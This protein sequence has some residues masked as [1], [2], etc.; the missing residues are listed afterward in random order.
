MFKPQHYGLLFTQEHVHQARSQRSRP[1]FDQAWQLLEHIETSNNLETAQIGG[2]RYRFNDDVRA[3]ESA[4][5][6]LVSVLNNDSSDHLGYLEALAEMMAFAQCFEMLRT[7]PAWTPDNQSHWLDTFWER[8]NILN[9]GPYGLERYEEI[10]LSALNLFAGIILERETLFQNGIDLFQQV[11]RSEIHPEGYLHKAIGHHDGHSFFRHLLS[12]K[13]LTL[14]AEAATHAGVDLWR[15]AFRDVS[16]MTAAAYVTFYYYYPEKWQWD[17]NIQDEI[18]PLFKQHCAFAEM[19]NH[20]ESIKATRML[21]DELRPIYEPY[22][23][24]LTTLT[25]GVAAKRGLFG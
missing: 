19:V 16:V 6:L 10:W 17:D 11:I 15:Y 3:G 5:H 20:H 25:H 22:G 21:L 18:I 9:E 23:G 7:H 8:V 13:A 1:P 12:I 2:L 4:V 24:G 14:I